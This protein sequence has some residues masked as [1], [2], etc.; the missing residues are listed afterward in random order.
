[1]K[2]LTICGALA[3]AAL[4]LV[5]GH[6]RSA[7]SGLTVH[8]WGTFTS[9][10]AD[11]GAPAD[12]N[13]LGCGS[14]LPRFVNDYGF[15]GFKA[16]LSGTVRMETPVIYF[17]S[18]RDL[19]ASVKVS[20]PNGLITEW[21]P[22]SDYRVFRKDPWNGLMFP[23]ASNLNGLGMDLMNQTGVIEWKSVKVRPGSTPDYPMESDPS[24]YYAARATGASPLSVGDQ[25]EK[26]LFYRGVAR[27]P[28][29]LSAR[30]TADGRIVVANTGAGDMPA[31]I[32]FENR[33]GAIGY[34]NAGC[35]EHGV[36]F[37]RPSLDGSQA[38]LKADLEGALI[39]QG[40]FPKEAE[41]MIDTWRDSWFEEG[42]RLIYILPESAVNAMLP[43]EINPAPERLARVF[44][45][46]I[47][48]ITPETK[49]AV[50]E[51]IAKKDR[52]TLAFYRRFLEPIGRS[53]DEAANLSC[54]TPDQR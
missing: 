38:Q 22:K 20:F 51:A 5:A 16:R 23:L 10:A 7:D 47:E 31:V 19:D 29:P 32:L 25:H 18:P 45:G 36:T 39:E 44:V 2:M 50:Q 53:L 42:S 15:R 37:E 3:C 12:W 54:Q 13:T 27:I 8:E 9:V 28:V 26:F 49:R 52:R 30:V 34:R 24:R 35:V 41:A 48:L 17:Y 14:D 43:L 11:N 33:G 1:M 46:R 4:C 40:L 6:S 21:Y